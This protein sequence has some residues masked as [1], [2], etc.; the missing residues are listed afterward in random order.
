MSPI[1]FSNTSDDGITMGRVV[2]NVLSAEKP[3]SFPMAVEFDR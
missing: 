1:E 2:S 3:D